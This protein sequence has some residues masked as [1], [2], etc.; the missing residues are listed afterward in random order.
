MD[1]RVKPGHHEL[2]GARALEMKILW[3]IVLA[4]AALL[5]ILFA[6]SNRETVSVGLWPL[7]A[8]VELPLYLVVLGTLIIGFVLGELV[9]WI[10]AW[11]WR[12]EARRSRE[13]IA[14]LERE[15]EAE[16]IQHGEPR[17]PVV[18]ISR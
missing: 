3:W 4:L 9:A 14:V 2:K 8:L 5:L 6:V 7:P 17:V 15:L 13:R 16:R 10:S 12:R 1:G 18:A 11:R